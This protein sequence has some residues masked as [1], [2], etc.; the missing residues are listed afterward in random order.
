MTMEH[1]WSRRFLG[2]V[3]SF[4]DPE[5]LRDHYQYPRELLGGGETPAQTLTRKTWE[6]ARGRYPPARHPDGIPPKVALQLRQ[7]LAHATHIAQLQRL[8]QRRQVLCR[9][10]G[11]GR[12]DVQAIARRFFAIELHSILRPLYGR[13]GGFCF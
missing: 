8:A 3:E 11:R 4:A 6:G 5:R 13:C 12:S 7:G 10:R 9:D 1:W 2:M